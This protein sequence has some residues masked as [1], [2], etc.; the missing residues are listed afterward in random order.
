MMEE[1]VALEEFK[2]TSKSE[3]VAEYYYYVYHACIAG[4]IASYILHVCYCRSV[5]ALCMVSAGLCM[6]CKLVWDGRESE[7]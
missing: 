4:P 5:S 6:A 7:M 2:N 3:P 1:Q